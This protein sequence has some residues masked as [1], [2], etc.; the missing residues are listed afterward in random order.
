M[1]LTTE[2]MLHV[3]TANLTTRPK[4]INKYD[5]KI[6]QISSTHLIYEDAEFKYIRQRLGRAKGWEK[7]VTDLFAYILCVSVFSCATQPLSDI[8]KF[9]IL[10]YQ[11]C[12]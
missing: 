4:L 2:K 3:K 9:R 8:F 5:I 7:V 12:R 10:V 1:P 6:A 11:A